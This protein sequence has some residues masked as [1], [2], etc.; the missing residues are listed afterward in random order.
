MERPERL[1]KARAQRPSGLR[2]SV[3]YPLLGFACLAVAVASFALL[4]NPA[5]MVRDRIAAH[6]KTRLDRDLLVSGGA[7]LTF[8][9][10]GVLLRDVELSSLSDAPGLVR[11]AAVD[12]RV[13]LL[14]LLRQRVAV[15]SV[16]MM[17]PE[18]SFAIDADGRRNWD[19][20]STDSSQR[21]LIRFAQLVPRFGFGKD[22]PQDLMDARAGDADGAMAH[23]LVMP[24]AALEVRV[25]D[26]TVR[27]SDERSGTKKQVTNVTVQMGLNGPERLAQLSGSFK[28]S[29]EPV[30][31]QASLDMHDVASSQ[32]DVRLKSRALEAAYK[33]RLLLAGGLE[34]D[35]R[36]TASAPSTDAL[37]QW[38]TGAELRIAPPPA[39]A[40]IGG[41]VKLSGTVLELVDASITAHGTTATGSVSVDVVAP[42]PLVRADLKLTELDFGRARTPS[43]SG[44]AGS[45]PRL[46]KDAA[47]KARSIDDLLKRPDDEI[48]KTEAPVAQPEPGHGEKTTRPF[49]LSI[50]RLADLDG[51]FEIGRLRW[52]NLDVGQVHLTATVSDGTFTANVT[53][54]NLYGGRGKGTLGVEARGNAAAVNINATIDGVATQALLKDLLD[55]DWLDGRGQLALVLSG[56]G[57]SEKQI[58]D[59]LQGRAEIKVADGALV[60]WDLNQM[61]RGLR[62]GN[63][64]ATDRHASARTSFGELTGSF[65]IA[66]GVAHNE[67]LKVI[68]RA[69]SLSGSGSIVYRDRTINYTVLPK[70]V[71]AA[72]GLEDI[73]I[74]VR[75]YGAWDKPV[76]SPNLDGVLKDPRA[77]AKVQQLGRQLRSGNVDEALK[78]VLGDGPEAE[79]KAEKAKSFL[80]RFLK[81]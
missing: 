43:S 14:S 26:G 45:P 53:E 61:L 69:V 4:A 10:F 48:A 50:L 28:W 3:F 35:G 36:L 18:I 56:E 67:D 78:S 29:D 59:G 44:A 2:A 34:L 12:V 63:L 79:K 19:F 30:S 42:R 38:I 41:R 8:F 37:V 39:G 62:Q 24:E 5:E 76:L 57:A 68:G 6:V 71:E 32:A 55:F 52:R 81:Q 74:P 15:S 73:E 54:A 80:K 22:L 13:S 58:V 70:L 65:V 27:Y 20:A 46:P 49:D 72:G 16:T 75:I 60:G 66:D 47:D 23:G 1:S 17:K 64:P 33:G 31:L 7:S 40:A 9:P 51:R 11:A 21:R 77:A 25:Q